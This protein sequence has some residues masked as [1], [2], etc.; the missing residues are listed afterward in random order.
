MHH[1]DMR[2]QGA[3]VTQPSWQALHAPVKL[4]R[5][6]LQSSCKMLQALH[7]AAKARYCQV[8]DEHS[9]CHDTLL[10]RLAGLLCTDWSGQLEVM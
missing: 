7:V 4:P 10:C 1:K 3:S 8:P 9:T 2:N 6:V 5:V